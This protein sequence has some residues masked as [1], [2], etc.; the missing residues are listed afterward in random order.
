[1]AISLKERVDPRQA[2][3]VILDMQKGSWPPRG[4]PAGGEEILPDLTLLISAARAAGVAIIF[5]RNTH[6]E[7][8]TTKSRKEQT[9]HIGV[10]YRTRYWEGTPGNDFLEGLNPQPE[11]LIFIKHSYSPYAHGPMDLVLRSRG[12]QTVLLTGGS[13]L[14]AVETVAKDSIVRGYNVVVVD[15]CVHP[16][17]GPIY[18][19]VIDYV[20]RHLGITASSKQIM[21]CWSNSTR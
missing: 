5:V 4:G 16:R 6:S 1:M 18:E 3:L 10:D 12:L 8:T 2:V 14:G 19:M 7:W 11:D 15:D 13:T 20:N 9:A 21:D 17:S